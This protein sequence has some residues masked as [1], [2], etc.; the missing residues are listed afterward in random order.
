MKKVNLKK[1][2]GPKMLAYIVKIP[3]VI[4]KSSLFENAHNYI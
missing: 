4:L 2:R 1:G 3:L